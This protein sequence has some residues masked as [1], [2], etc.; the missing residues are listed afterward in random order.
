MRTAGA[1]AL[2]IVGT[3][4][5]ASDAEAL[6]SIALRAGLPTICASRL[7][8]ER[9]CLVGYGPNLPEL[10]RRVATYVVRIFQGAD[11][12]ELP[13]EGPTHIELVLNLKTAHALG[14]SLPESL[15]ARADAVIE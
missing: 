15:I 8:A 2:M 4:E 12:G 14:V 7:A 6:A 1:Q 11:P 9:G 3:P 13:I 5:L 10:Y